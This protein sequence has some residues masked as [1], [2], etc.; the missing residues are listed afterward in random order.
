MTNSLDAGVTDASAV[1]AP[2]VQTALPQLSIQFWLML[3]LPLAAFSLVMLVR[4]APWSPYRLDRK[5]LSCD[6]CMSFWVTFSLAFP[7]GWF[8]NAAWPWVLLHTAATPGAT[9]FLLQLHRWLT[10]QELPLLPPFDVR[11]NDDI[12]P[13]PT[14]PHRRPRR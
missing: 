1:G 10:V 2:A 7:L 5:P 12:K 14:A 9:M 13:K 8:F 6:A 11:S 3:L 4:A